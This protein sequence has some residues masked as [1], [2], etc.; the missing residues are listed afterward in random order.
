MTRT[1]PFP[2][3][4]KFNHLLTR[5]VDLRE[6]PTA[7]G[8]FKDI[9]NLGVPVNNYTLPIVLKSYCHCN[10][11][12]YGFLVLGMFFKRGCALS[13]VT[14]ST[15]LRGLFMENKI[16]EALELFLKITIEDLCEVDTILY[17]IVIEGL[18]KKMKIDTALKVFDEM[19][20]KG[21]SPNVIVYSSL[22]CGLCR[23]ICDS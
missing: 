18:C 3:V 8:L 16:N 9:C 10:R 14:F 15:L 11:A 6:H 17:G 21:I 12:D 20:D 5:L 7:I 19:C 1:K 2:S 23:P 22:I 13:A 4:K